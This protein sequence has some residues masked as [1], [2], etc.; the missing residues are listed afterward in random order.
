MRLDRAAASYVDVIH[1]DAT[2]FIRGGLG[3]IERIGHVDY[4]PNNGT[5]QPGCGKSVGQYISAE[6]GSFLQGNFY[7]CELIKDLIL[8]HLYI[9]IILKDIHS[10]VNKFPIYV[11]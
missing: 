7:Y 9:I 5:H 1:T 8:S 2:G 11:T 6:S 10:K 3:I 4:Y